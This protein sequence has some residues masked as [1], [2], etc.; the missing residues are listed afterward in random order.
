[1]NDQN[2]DNWI[3]GTEGTLF[4]DMKLQSMAKNEPYTPPQTVTSASTKSTGSDEG[5]SI[6]GFFAFVAA[7]AAMYFSHKAQVAWEW[8]WWA[9]LF[10]GVLSGV[11]MLLIRIPLLTKLLS[12]ATLAFFIAL[13]IQN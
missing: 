6:E 7:C 12:L 5:I 1:M 3:R 9:G 8:Y 4:G 11:K 10:L 2:W 13:A